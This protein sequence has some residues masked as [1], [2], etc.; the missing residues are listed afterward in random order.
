MSLLFCD[1]FISLNIVFFRFAQVAVTTECPYLL[2]DK[3][4]HFV[5]PF[6]SQE[7]LRLL[8]HFSYST[9]GILK[10]VPILLGLQTAQDGQIMLL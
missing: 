9:H 2:Y 5:D 6:I 7:P 1:W 3:E 8:W 4:R 10:S